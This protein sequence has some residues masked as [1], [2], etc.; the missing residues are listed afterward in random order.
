MMR[1][2][3]RKV[4]TILKTLLPNIRHC[5]INL[6]HKIIREEISAVNTM[7]EIQNFAYVNKHSLADVVNFNSYLKQ[8][9]E[10]YRK[11]I[12]Q[13]EDIHALEHALIES[14][15]RKLELTS[16]FDIASL[17][18]NVKI[19]N[20]EAVKQILEN[21]AKRMP[22]TP[23]IMIHQ[24]LARNIRS[25]SRK[26]DDQPLDTN[27][28]ESLIHICADEL[29]SRSKID[30]INLVER[31]VLLRCASKSNLPFKA[32]TQIEYNRLIDLC[33]SEISAM[34][35]E[36]IATFMKE[37]VEATPVR[38]EMAF[39]SPVVDHLVSVFEQKY[40]ESSTAG[41]ILDFV[42]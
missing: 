1:L 9:M 32:T 10:L 30:E 36:Q 29:I 35:P 12:I 14:C 13:Q 2:S 41:Q 26:R 21:T 38:Q 25:R 37:M 16:I 31:M 19:R 8:C 39:K 17:F 22:K 7:V 4:P 3:H 11:G 24:N 28:A 33:T 42:S 23:T 34:T 18:K 15:P 6:T 27:F 20:T 5:H 40:I